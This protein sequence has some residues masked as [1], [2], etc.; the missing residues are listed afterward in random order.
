MNENKKDSEMSSAS[1]ESPEAAPVVERRKPTVYITQVPHTYDRDT[2]AFVPLF[3]I[4]PAAEHGELLVMMPPRASFYATADLIKQLR[5]HLQHYD[6]NAGDTL[7]AM[8]D[9]AIIAV[10]CALLGRMFGNFI[11]LKWDRKIERY[12]PTHVHI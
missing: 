10:A 3:N 2:N 5:K 9:P 8:G 1:V 7:V 12:V 11:I 6:Y 4:G